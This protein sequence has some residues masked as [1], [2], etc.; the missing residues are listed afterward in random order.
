EYDKIREHAWRYRDYVVQSFNEDKPYFQFVKEEIAGDALTPVTRDGVIATGFLVAGPYDEAGNTSAS[1]LL[2]ARIRE[3]ELEDMIGTVGQTFLGL[4]VNCARCHD[5]KFDPILQR[6]YYRFK[7]TFE[8]VRHGERP[9]LGAEESKI[10][11]QKQTQLETNIA[12]LE[13]RIRAIDALGRAR[14]IARLER[15]AN[16]SESA[17]LALPK[18]PLPMARWTFETNANDGIGH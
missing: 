16:S 1:A 13:D 4:T 2:K 6:D 12:E 7:A 14:A 18:P 10:R 5:H 17:D 8:G 9:C 3:E 11:E 15:E